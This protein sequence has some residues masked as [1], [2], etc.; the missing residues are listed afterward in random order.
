[1]QG[2][3]PALKGAVLVLCAYETAAIVSGRVPTV[4]ALSRRYRAV[5]VALIAAFIADVHTHER[6]ADRVKT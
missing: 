5:E 6:T 3:R 1:M 4:T 2:V